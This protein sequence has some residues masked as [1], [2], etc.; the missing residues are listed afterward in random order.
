MNEYTTLPEL[1]E[2]LSLASQNT[3]DDG[4][5]NRFIE[6]AAR[7]IDRTCRRNFYPRRLTLK[8]DLPEDESVLDFQFDV[9]E[10][11]GLS[12][13]NGASFITS[14]SYFLKTGNVYN[15][16]PYTKIELN[17][18]FGRLFNYSSTPQQAVQ[19]DSVVGYHEDYD[20]AW[21]NTN[22]TLTS[23]ATSA[24]T[25]LTI[26]GSLI[27]DVWGNPSAIKAK[28]IIKIDEEYFYVLSGSNDVTINTK[29]AINGTS[30]ASHAAN[31]AIYVW[32]PEYDIQFANKELAAFQY[33]AAQSPRTGRTIVPSY[34]G[35]TIDDPDSWP[36]Q[37]RERL[38]RYI[39]REVYNLGFADD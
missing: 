26:S 4:T 7:T 31:M 5:L 32:K 10:V 12:D 3:T 9:L 15:L 2:Y 14:G 18:A 1:R 19:V 13:M 29:R 16:T 20:N 28:N 38:E 17:W 23:S 11:K 8:Y 21:I 35:F 25:L 34:G 39:N 36:S 37:T 30:A 22:A 27:D 6:Q 24:Q 33:M